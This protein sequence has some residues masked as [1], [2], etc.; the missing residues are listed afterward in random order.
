MRH[1]VVSSVY[2]I[3]NLRLWEQYLLKRQ[4]FSHELQNRTCFPRVVHLIPGVIELSRI[5]SHISLEST[6]NE[7]LVFHGTKRDNV[8]YIVNQ[9]FDE[10]LCNRGHYGPGTYFTS[11]ACKAIQYCDQLGSRCI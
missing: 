2:G 9:G 3:M 8:E 1:V 5:F 4:Q 11:D 6:I 7:V 10:R